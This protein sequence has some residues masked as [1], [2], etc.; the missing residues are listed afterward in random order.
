MIESQPHVASYYAATANR[1]TDYPQLRG[2][3]KCDVCVIG[4][5]ITGLSSSFHLVTKGYEV[6]LLEANRIGWGA[7]GRN[8][9][10][11]I[12]GYSCDMGKIRGLVGL[13]QARMLWDM[14]SEAVSLTRGLI[15]EH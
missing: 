5:G 6:I 1:Q 7:S 14:S 8:G 3:Q 9:G 2:E 11:C 13:K 4:G 12:F 15:D 10:Q